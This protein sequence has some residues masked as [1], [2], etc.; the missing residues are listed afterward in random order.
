MSA[1]V[2]AGQVAWNHRA[3]RLVI[4]VTVEA[5][6]WASS[7][8]AHAPTIP[9]PLA[10]DDSDVTAPSDVHVGTLSSSAV[11][12]APAS[13]SLA[14]RQPASDSAVTTAATGPRLSVG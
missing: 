7:A 9:P 11:A 10:T 12:V 14:S 1:I 13:G 4:S 6:P 3:P 5:Q 8:R 2:P